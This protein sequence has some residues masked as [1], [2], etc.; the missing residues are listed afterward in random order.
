[1]DYGAIDLH[2]KESQIRSSI[3]TARS[4]LKRNRKQGQLHTSRGAGL[5]RVECGLDDGFYDGVADGLR[6]FGCHHAIAIRGAREE[7][8]SPRAP[9]GS[10]R[11]EE[12]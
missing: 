2:A 5:R 8:S 11:S 4:Y 7:L 3:R 6:H 12:A 10:K 9:K 1:M